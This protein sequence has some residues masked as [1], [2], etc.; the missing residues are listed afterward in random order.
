MAK[1]TPNAA[2]EETQDT[3]VLDMLANM[4][5]QLDTL[6]KEN[7]QLKAAVTTATEPAAEKPAPTIP[8][9]TFT[10]PDGVEY[11]FIAAKFIFNKQ[12]VT[13]TDALSDAALLARLVDS[14]SG[15]IVP[16]K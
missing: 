7:E 8:T 11:K 3:T 13:A 6:A 14:G 1:N 16:A 9:Q 10:G 15:L 12:E 2:G 5:K 4:Q